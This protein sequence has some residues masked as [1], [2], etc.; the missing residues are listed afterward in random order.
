MRDDRQH[1]LDIPVMQAQHNPPPSSSFNLS[2]WSASSH[3]S[4]FPTDSSGVRKV[5][6]RDPDGNEIGFGVASRVRTGRTVEIEINAARSRSRRRTAPRA[7]RG[8]SAFLGLAS[9]E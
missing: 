8:R 7:H 9:R 4:F 1:A 3:T 6:Y 5:T 2:G